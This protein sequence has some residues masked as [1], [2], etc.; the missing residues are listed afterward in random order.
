MGLIDQAARDA[1]ANATRAAREGWADRRHRPNL[2]PPPNG[3]P[4]VRGGSRRGRK[5]ASS[6]V[7]AGDRKRR[8]G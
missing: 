5:A 8:G 1:Q 2:N 3:V 6:T 4:Y 7:K